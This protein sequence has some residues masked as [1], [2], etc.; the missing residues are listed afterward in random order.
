MHPY[1][2]D[3]QERK[4]IPLFIA[5]FAVISALAL[6]RLLQLIHW[7]GWVDAPATMGFYGIYYD[8]FRRWFWRIPLLHTLGIVKGAA[9]H[10]ALGRG[11]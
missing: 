9:P 11:T 4:T 8:L 6:S 2:T 1:A 5:A 10:G 7:P 3:S